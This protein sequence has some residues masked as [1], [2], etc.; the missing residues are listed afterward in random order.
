MLTL[1]HSRY[2]FFTVCT[3]RIKEWTAHTNGSST[4]SEGLHD[5]CARAEAPVYHDLNL[6]E[7][8]WFEDSNLIENIDWSWCVVC[9]ATAMI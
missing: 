6:V 1:N 2:T 8:V 5:V 9:L 7:E 3:V 4:K